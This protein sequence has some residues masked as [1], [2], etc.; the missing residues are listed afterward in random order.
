MLGLSAGAMTAVI[1]LGLSVG[2]LAET[3]PHMLPFACA[4]VPAIFGMWADWAR[5]WRPSKSAAALSGAV[6]I[7][8]FSLAIVTDLSPLIVACVGVG[9]AILAWLLV[10]LRLALSPRL[11][12]ARWIEGRVRRDDGETLVLHTDEGPL[13]VNR[14]LH[15]EL[16]PRR[17]VDIGVGAKLCVL[18]RTEVTASSCVPFRSEREHNAAEI[19]AVGRDRADIRT[20]ARTRAGWW[21]SY[22]VLVGI[23]AALLGHFGSHQE[24]PAKRVYM[25]PYS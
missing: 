10:H 22:L 25:T 5:M 12:R 7:G 21:M 24:Q 3:P 23:G 4:P 17:T 20:R 13:R 11:S 15:D 6:M 18:A 1:W 16:G 2:P 8:A 14:A 9:L 19:V